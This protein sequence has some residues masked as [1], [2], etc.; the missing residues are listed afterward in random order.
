MNTPTFSALPG[1]MRSG[2]RILVDALCGNGVDRVFCVPGE[3]YLEVL[4]ALIDTNI[5]VIVARHEGAAANMAEADGKLTGRP[6]ICFVTRGPGAT[7]ASVGVHT[8]MQD[9]TPMILF[10]GQ[11]DRAFRGRE[12]FQ[13]V[14]YRHMFA[15]LAKWVAEIDDP[16]RIPEFV[17]RAFQTAT[18]DRPGPVVLSLP[19]DML[20]E[21]CMAQDL[22]ENFPASAEPSKQDLHA[23]KNELARAQRPL[24]ILGGSG[25]T[26]AACRDIAAFAEAHALPVAAGFRRQHLF[27]NNHPNYVGHIGLGIDPNLAATVRDA[28]LLLAIGT[29]LPEASSQSYALIQAP[30]PQQ[31]MIH[32]HADVN[33]LGRVYRADLMV[34]ASMPAVASA[35][36]HLAPD[37]QARPPAWL[38][39]ARQ[40]FIDFT[41]PPAPAPDYEGVDLAQAV[42]HLSAVLPEDAIICNGAGNYTIWVHRFYLYRRLLSQLAPTSGAMGYGLPAAIAAKL[43]FPERTVVCFAGDGCFLMYPQELATACQFQIPIIVIVVNNGMYG[44]IRMHQERHYPGRVAHTRLHNPDFPSLARSFGAYA[45]RVEKTKDF[46]PAFERAQAAG[47]PALLEL[48]V[49]PLQLTPAMRLKPDSLHNMNAA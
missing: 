33:E 27:D 7:H 37:W 12:A 46:A 26:D 20:E 47:L 4:D 2:G 42:A 28:D 13:E 8:A 45:E 10:I 31:R 43:R 38:L 9:S 30:R 21:Q 36:K 6:G 11:V 49:D 35:L 16:V 41:R 24:I 44:T 5:N 14:E 17:A 29:R 39:Q 48:A 32:I 19:G 25:W 22:Q 40:N 18:S 34:H 3:S 15:P 23:L 1:K